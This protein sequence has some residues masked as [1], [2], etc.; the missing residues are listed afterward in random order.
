MYMTQRAV[1]GMSRDGGCF[2]F[3]LMILI[4]FECVVIMVELTI[5]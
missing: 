1:P 4:L 3:E 2:L 5:T